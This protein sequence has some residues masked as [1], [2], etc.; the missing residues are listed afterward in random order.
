MGWEIMADGQLLYSGRVP[1]PDIRP[2]Q[3]ERIR[4][5]WPFF[6][7]EPGTEYHIMF[8]TRTRQKTDLFPEGFPVAWDQFSLPDYVAPVAGL[9]ADADTLVLVEHNGKIT[10]SVSGMRIAFNDLGWNVPGK[11]GIWKN[12]GEQATM[13]KFEVLR[14]NTHHIEVHTEFE[15]PETGSALMTDY[16]VTGNGMITITHHF[17]PGREGLPNLPRLGTEFIL[18]PDF[19]RLT[20]YGRGPH[21]T[22][23][24]RKTGAPIH[25]YHGAVREQFHRYVRPQETGNKT[26]VRWLALQ[27]DSLT[28]LLI[29]GDAR[30][31]FSAWPFAV[32]QLE[33]TPSA[34]G[35]RH[36]NDILEETLVTLNIDHAQMGVGGDNSWGLPVHDE[37]Q[38]PS[39]LYS[40]T[41]ALKPFRGGIP[42]MVDQ[43]KRIK[44]D[45]NRLKDEKT[46]F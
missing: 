19:N 11:M 46:S 37:Y 35:N 10:I 29:V 13:T 20:W 21:E 7:P 36:G 3:T 26:D 33:W 44:A 2:H 40:W 23:T 28:G 24:D 22:Y 39:K 31:N 38:V 32:Q 15:F 12:E 30:L 25:L 45:L 14:K 34:K 18:T 42:D 16:G 1:I 9:Q 43:Y 4:I 8:T 5:D 41:Y 17:M 27:N 6:L